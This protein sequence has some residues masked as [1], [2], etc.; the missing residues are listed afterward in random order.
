MNASWRK[1]LHDKL[2]QSYLSW[3]LCPPVLRPL[4]DEEHEQP[5]EL[6][7]DHQAVLAGEEDVHVADDAVPGHHLRDR[8]QDEDDLLEYEREAEADEGDVLKHDGQHDGDDVRVDVLLVLAGEPAPGR[9]L[10]D[11]SD[12]AATAGP[13]AHQVPRLGS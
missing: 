8:G 10:A 13:V 7:E 5:V 9:A 11:L 3:S 1:Y 12:V 2:K 6:E 4:L